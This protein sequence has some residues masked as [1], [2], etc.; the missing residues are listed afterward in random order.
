[1]SI[2]GYNKGITQEVLEQEYT[3]VGN[4]SFYLIAYRDPV[5]FLTRDF[6]I[7]TTDGVM[8]EKDTDYEFTSLDHF[9][10]AGLY[11]NEEVASTV[12]VKNPAYQ[13]GTLLISYRWVADYAS[14]EMFNRFDRGLDQMIDSI[15]VDNSGAVVVSEAGNVVVRGEKYP[16]YRE[17][18]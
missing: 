8:L 5:A 16:G 12:R 4:D 10:S 17:E 3:N 9:Y 6:F 7:E 13:T 1:M 2:R 14:A 15:I 11:E 18:L